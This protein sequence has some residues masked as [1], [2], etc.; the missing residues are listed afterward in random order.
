MSLN[1]NVLL[2]SVYGNYISTEILHFIYKNK[3]KQI[4]NATF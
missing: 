2:I 4:F 1:D 3:E